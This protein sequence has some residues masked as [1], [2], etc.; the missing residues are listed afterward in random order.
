MAEKNYGLFW[1][2]ITRSYLLLQGPDYAVKSSSYVG[3]VS[4]SS[5]NHKRSTTTIGIC[6]C[7]LPKRRKKGRKGPE[8]ETLLVIGIAMNES[9]WSS[10]L[11]VEEE[12]LHQLQL[13]HTARPPLHLVLHCIQHNS[14]A[15][16]RNQDL[17]P[18]RNKKVSLV[19]NN[20]TRS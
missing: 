18:Y 7:T 20:R 8:Y 17:Q 1:N 2:L 11:K 16:R 19:R 14:L 10:D 9:F 3:K 15:R 4:Y 6:S 5:S 12:C 13:W